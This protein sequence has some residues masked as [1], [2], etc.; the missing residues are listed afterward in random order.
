MTARHKT[1]WERKRNAEKRQRANAS[2]SDQEV[3]A[4]RKAIWEG[5]SR[6]DLARF[7]GVGLETIARIARGDTY[8]WVLESEE[9]Q[10]KIEAALKLGGGKNIPKEQ[11]AESLAR[12]QEM[13]ASPEGKKE[14]PYAKAFEM[15]EGQRKIGPPP[16]LEEEE[17]EVPLLVI[18]RGERGG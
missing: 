8:W 6:R 5:E 13:L 12:V 7:Y 17:L 14:D 16:E 18:P 2:F 4:I 9:E 15:L 1:E 3:R 10:E 11:I